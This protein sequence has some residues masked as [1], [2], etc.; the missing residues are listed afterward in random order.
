MKLIK[1][2]Y[3]ALVGLCLLVCSSACNKGAQQN[4]TDTD[5][6]TAEANGEEGVEPVADAAGA[7]VDTDDGRVVAELYADVAPGPAV[8]EG[9]DHPADKI[10]IKRNTVQKR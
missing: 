10:I 9:T 5:D 4:T 6:D 8:S 2:W 7:V 3:V 1:L